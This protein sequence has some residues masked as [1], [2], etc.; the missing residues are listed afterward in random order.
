MGRRHKDTTAITPAELAAVRAA[1]TPLPTIDP[2]ADSLRPTPKLIDLNYI[3]MGDVRVAS[4]TAPIEAH[5]TDEAPE[6][7]QLP[8]ATST[9]ATE[10]GSG[11]TRPRDQY[12]RFY[13]GPPLPPKPPV[14]PK[15]TLESKP[16]AGLVQGLSL[17]PMSWPPLSDN[18]SLQAELG[19]VQSQ[20]LS[21]VEER[22]NTT[23]VHL[24]RASSPAPSKAALGWLETSIRSYAKY[25]DIVAKSLSTQ[26]DEQEHIRRERMAIA[27][28]DALLAEMHDAKS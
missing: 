3:D 2:I 19:W 17:I 22:G 26:V 10:P 25:I 6:S 7:N 20:R 16:D 28:I 23:I 14:A 24:E 13:S 5:S 15:V 21:I 9:Q 8:E 4:S 1:L 12:G 11:D 18:S 27:E